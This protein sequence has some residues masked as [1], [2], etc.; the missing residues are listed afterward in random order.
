MANRNRI[1]TIEVKKYEILSCCEKSGEFVSWEEEER[2][3]NE[4]NLERNNIY[5]ENGDRDFEERLIKRCGVH[6]RISY[7][8]LNDELHVYRKYRWKEYLLKITYIYNKKVFESTAEY[9]SDFGGLQE[10]SKLYVSFY[11]DNP[12][13]AVSV[14]N[15]HSSITTFFHTPFIKITKLFK[16]K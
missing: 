10:N 6:D 15:E 13:H 9:E 7:D 8:D 16:K 1:V 4:M 2:I 14:S 3:H 11:K 5:F 12:A